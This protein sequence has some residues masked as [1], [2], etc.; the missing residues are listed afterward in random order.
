MDAKTRAWNFDEEWDLYTI[1]QDL[2]PPVLSEYYKKYWGITLHWRILADST[3]MKWSRLKSPVVRKIQT[4]DKMPSETQ[5]HIV[6][7]L[8]KMCQLSGQEN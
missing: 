7:F 6:V 8:L 2:P 4:S 3:L 1:S 5:L